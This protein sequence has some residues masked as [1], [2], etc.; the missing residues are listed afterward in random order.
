V[1]LGRLLTNP[2]LQRLFDTQGPGELAI[3][4]PQ[5]YTNHLWRSQ[6]IGED[7]GVGFM[8]E[9]FF[10]T[11]RSLEDKSVTQ[12]SRRLIEATFKLRAIIAN[13]RSESF[14][15]ADKR[16]L[17]SLKQELDILWSSTHKIETGEMFLQELFNEF[18]EEEAGE[19]NAGGAKNE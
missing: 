10:A 1:G 9:M 11:F 15:T 13:G 6:G 7:G 3:R 17:W 2:E 4:S 8:V 5:P 12:E 18:N 19:R 14:K 16:F